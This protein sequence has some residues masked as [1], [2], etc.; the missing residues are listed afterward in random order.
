[1]RFYINN[2]YKISYYQDNE[3]IEIDNGDVEDAEE[4]GANSSDRT[5]G[6]KKPMFINDDDE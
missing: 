2:K 3:K 6:A 5:K 1:M 4:A